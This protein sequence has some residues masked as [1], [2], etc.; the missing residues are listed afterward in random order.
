MTW[1]LGGLL[2]RRPRASFRPSSL[3]CFLLCVS[4][5]INGS[6]SKRT[7]QGYEGF[8]KIFVSAITTKIVVSWRLN[9]HQLIALK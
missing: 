3:E 1:G 2:C 8:E 6:Q 9:L 4:H 5:C 7:V